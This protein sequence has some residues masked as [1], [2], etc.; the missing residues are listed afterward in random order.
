MVGQ[1]VHFKGQDVQWTGLP[2]CGYTP[3]GCDA[4]DYVYLWMTV[5]SMVSLTF[6]RALSWSGIFVDIIIII[7]IEEES[8]MLA[9]L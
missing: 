2:K 6:I 3:D 7:I 1:S 8:I 4:S 9:E 5:I